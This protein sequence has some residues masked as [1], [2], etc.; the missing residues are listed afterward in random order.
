MFDR[1]EYIDGLSEQKKNGKD[2]QASALAQASISAQT[3][4]ADPNWDRYLS[5]LQE[6]INERHKEAEGYREILASPTVV[7][8]EELLKAKIGLL[9]TIASIVAWEWAMSIPKKL[10]EGADQL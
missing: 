1:Q 3:M 10:K 5:Y 2:L 6:S 4:T 7:N 8:Y 9:T